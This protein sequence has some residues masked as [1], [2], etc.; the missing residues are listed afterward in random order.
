MFNLGYMHQYG[1]GL[2]RDLH[3]AK[4]FYDTAESTHADAKVPVSLAL[5][6]LYAHRMFRAV[7]FGESS[8]D[9]PPVV[10]WLANWVQYLAPAAP[11]AG[12]IAQPSGG[13]GD[14]GSASAQDRHVVGGS[15]SSS[16]SSSS[17]ADDQQPEDI[18]QAILDTVDELED[19]TVVALC[20]SVLL[21]FVL[22]LRAREQ[23]GVQAPHEHA[24]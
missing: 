9:L 10:A 13:G 15:S 1:I 20:L 12:G 3:L 19:D 16:S 8:A 21:C 24:D 23:R 5:S 17:E 2:P 22:Y 6:G 4:R 14:R 7:W 18:M 11:A